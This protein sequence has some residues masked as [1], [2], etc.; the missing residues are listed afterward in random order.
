MGHPTAPGLNSLHGA[1]PAPDVNPSFSIDVRF[2][3]VLRPK[4]RVQASRLWGVSLLVCSH[5][6]GPVLSVATTIPPI[7]NHSSEPAR[8]RRERRRRADARVILRI[9]GA[10]G[11]L[12]SHHS[13]MAPQQQ[14]HQPKPWWQCGDCTHRNHGSNQCCGG[15]G[16]IKTRRS[17]DLPGKGNGKERPSDGGGKDR[18][19]NGSSGRG[20]GSSRRNQGREDRVSCP[21]VSVKEQHQ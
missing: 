20:R 4:V 14:Q 5:V 6:H 1:C 21:N 18:G 12:E 8:H 13:S 11:L 9:A 10:R 17:T 2:L 16:V 15:C 3:S 19:R 7:T